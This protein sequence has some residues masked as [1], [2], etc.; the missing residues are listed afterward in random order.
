MPKNRLTHALRDG[1][2]V[3]VGDAYHFYRHLT[4]MEEFVGGRRMQGTYDVRS[5]RYRLKET[6]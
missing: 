1:D 6:E 2:A 4:V 3:A 5:L